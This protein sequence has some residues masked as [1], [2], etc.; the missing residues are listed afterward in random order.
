MQ[1]SVNPL[2]LVGIIGTIVA[3]FHFGVEYGRAMWGSRDIWWTPKSVAFPLDK[4]RQEFEL[5][6]SGE[7]L[8]DHLERSSLSATD[9]NGKSYQIVPDDIEVR[10]NN[11]HKVKASFLNSA[12]FSAFMLGVSSTCLVMGVMQLLARRKKNRE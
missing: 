9:S 7:L 12:V 8:Q 6:L 5:F 2:L 11:W 10:L 4:T 1:K 3:G